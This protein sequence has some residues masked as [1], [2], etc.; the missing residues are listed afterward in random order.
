MEAK[1]V[2][3]PSLDKF[4]PEGSFLREEVQL[5]NRNRGM[6]LE[7]LR[8]PVTPTG[9]HYLLTHFDIPYVDASSWRLKVEGLVSNPATLSLNDVKA[10]P[11]VTT[12]VTMECAGNGRAFMTPRAV[13]QPWHLEAIS[14]A[15]WTGTP[16]KG[17]LREAGLRNSSVEVLF[18]GLDHGLEAGEFS[19]YQRSLS[20]DEASRDEVLLAY[21]MN[22][23]PL[24]PQHGHPLRLVVPGWYGMTSMKWLGSVEVIA[25]RSKGSR[26]RLTDIGP[27]KKTRVNPSRW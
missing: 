22:G 12:A 25:S 6:P 19:Y 18:T 27:P 16:L 15:E 10:M 5:A 9:L 8:Y 17:V 11:K 1:K 20:I 2:D 14:T 21:E 26:W 4:G 7:A 3:V 24:E 23:S 13:S